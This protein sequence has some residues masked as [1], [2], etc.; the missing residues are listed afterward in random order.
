MS[1]NRK[2]A[3]NILLVLS[4]GA[5]LVIFGGMAARYFDSANGRPMPPNL[6]WVVR[7]LDEEAQAQ[8]KPILEGYGDEIRPMRHALFQAQREVNALLIKDP[9][10]TQEIASAFA[11]L[12][13]VGMQYQNRSHEQT[14]ELFAQ[15]SPEQRVSAMRLVQERSRPP[16]G[17]SRSR[18][19][20]NESRDADQ[21][22]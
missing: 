5:N 6:S 4:L 22:R 19:D 15:L 1:S 20:R 18:D 8:L 21:A 7:E 3:L 2:R 13:K 10:N 12:R 9:L 14:L 17:E 11:A 16:G